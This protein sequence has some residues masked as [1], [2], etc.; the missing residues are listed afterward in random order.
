MRVGWK[1]GHSDG[2]A[3]EVASDRDRYRFRHWL[4][5]HVWPSCGTTVLTGLLAIAQFLWFDRLFSLIS[6]VS[7][8]DCAAT[9]DPAEHAQCKWDALTKT[10]D[11]VA[12]IGAGV[13]VFLLMALVHDRCEKLENLFG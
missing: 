2:V 13:V 12:S 1:E 10:V 9:I 4:D 7:A 3:R 11:L 8:G 6:D 5:V